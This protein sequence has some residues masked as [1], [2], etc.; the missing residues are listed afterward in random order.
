M[1]E[2]WK[3]IKG[4]EGLYQVSN[5]GRIKSFPRNG[6]R[7]KEAAILRGHDT[8]KGY[9]Q[10]CLTKDRVR[11]TIKIHRLVAEAFLP[12]PTNLPQINHKDENKQNNRVDNLEWCDCRYNNCYNGRMEKIAKKNGRRVRCLETDTVY[13]S[14]A[15]AAEATGISHSNIVYVCQGEFKQIKGFHF[16][17]ED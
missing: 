8:P 11:K 5:L 12:N 3:D 1:N 17:Y 15:K 9:M 13:D 6:T 4:Y 14:V 7:S 10:I 2:I 16:K